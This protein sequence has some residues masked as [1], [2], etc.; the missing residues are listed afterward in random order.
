[1]P[2]Y[3]SHYCNAVALTENMWTG[4]GTN[5]NIKHSTNTSK[6]WLHS[7]MVAALETT[8]FP[9]KM[10]RFLVTKSNRQK[11]V[12]NFVQNFVYSGG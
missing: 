2:M 5:Y 6:A 4:E 8:R 1:M 7:C 12:Q 9:L 3:F 10:S 11:A